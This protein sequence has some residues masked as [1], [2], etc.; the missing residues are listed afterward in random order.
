MSCTQTEGIKRRG[1]NLIAKQLHLRF[2]TLP[3]FINE[4]IGQASP[5]DVDIWAE[6]LLMAQTVEEVFEGPVYQTFKPI[7]KDDALTVS[8]TLTADTDRLNETEKVEQ[9]QPGVFFLL[10][11]LLQK[12][13]G[14]LPEE[15]KVKL[16]QASSEQLQTW[17]ERLLDAET[18]DEVL[19]DQ[20]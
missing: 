1:R 9:F 18:L 8:D 14:S 6:R 7:H 11:K 15:Y 20:A 17:G 16:Q 19:A 13:F 2:G 4:K 12:R 10:E 5:E 3:A